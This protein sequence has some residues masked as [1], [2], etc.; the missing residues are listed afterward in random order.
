VV[1]IYRTCKQFNGGVPYVYLFDYKKV[2]RGDIVINGNELISYPTTDVYEF[3]LN[4]SSNLSIENKKEDLGDYWDISFSLKLPNFDKDILKK[5][6]I[7]ITLDNNGKYR[8]LGLYNGLE[9]EKITK[10]SG[11][12]KSDF[13]GIEISFRGQE[14]IN[15]YFISNLENAGF[16][17]VGEITFD[18]LLQENGD[19]LLQ[20]NGFKIIL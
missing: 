2:S 5:D 15:P 9:I 11:G 6:L 10:S 3:E 8:I 14:K 16:N 17:V 13:N 12:A 4:E 18:Y 19:F 1:G 20:E 7:A